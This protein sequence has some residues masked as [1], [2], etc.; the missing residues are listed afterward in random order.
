VYSL[1]VILGI[2][3]VSILASVVFPEK[4]LEEEKVLSNS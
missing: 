2:L 1:Y 3:A 4:K